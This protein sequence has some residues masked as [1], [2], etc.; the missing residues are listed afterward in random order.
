MG[1][2]NNIE[3]YNSC[4]NEISK[5]KIEFNEENKFTSC[6]NDKKD[7]YAMVDDNEA[8]L[9]ISFFHNDANFKLKNSFLNKYERNS[10]SF[11]VKRKLY[12]ITIKEEDVTFRPLFIKKFEQIAN[13][14]ASDEEKAKKLDELF[15]D[16]GFYVP[17]KAYIGGLYNLGNLSEK[18]KMEFNYNIESGLN[19]KADFIL[20]QKFNKKFGQ[21]KSN[22]FSQS[23]KLFIGGELSNSFEDWI[24]SLNMKNSAIIEY[25]EFRKIYDFLDEKLTF[26]L[27][28]PIELMK[29]KYKR[30]EEYFQ[31][32]QELEKNKGNSYYSDRSDTLRLGIYEKKN[33]NIYCYDKISFW[34]DHGIIFKKKKNI[35]QSFD[36][37]IV[38]IEIISR[39][40]GKYTLCNPI[41]KKSTDIDFVSKRWEDMA[42]DIKV[43][44]MK[45][46][47]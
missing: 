21:E 29:E 33:K 7:N 13:I 44:L 25:T 18:E 19:I 45:F 15:K 35:Y 3:S 23:S 30:R 10:S 20:N 26:K 9:G 16:I 11:I 41:L 31:I 37:I 42:F 46:P 47:E 28:K 40:D 8:S 36:D 1:D 4:L 12:S 34:Q 43:Y 6:Q 24:N 38:G 17:L 39:T 32:I 22:D 27:Y 14:P 5:N 2:N